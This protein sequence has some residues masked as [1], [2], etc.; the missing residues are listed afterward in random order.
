MHVLLEREQVSKPRYTEVWNTQSISQYL[1][2][3]LKRV[4]GNCGYGA[5]FRAGNS[6][7]EKMMIMLYHITA[8]QI[9][10]S[11]RCNTELISCKIHCAREY[12]E[13]CVIPKKSGQRSK[14][15][16]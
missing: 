13:S 11:L 14:V 6:L 12:F 8:W 15:C 4:M 9:Q 5:H 1:C 10:L 3:H 7:R 2:T 16:K